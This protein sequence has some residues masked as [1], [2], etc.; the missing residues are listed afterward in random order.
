M[1]ER[2]SKTSVS[3]TLPGLEAFY[4]MLCSVDLEEMNERKGS[5]GSFS[6]FS[7]GLLPAAIESIIT[8][9]ARIWG[10]L[11]EGSRSSI[12]LS[13]QAFRKH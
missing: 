10:L 8:K 13:F 7:P 2:L 9:K 11:G 3:V 6:G 12:G 1:S 4:A 5:H